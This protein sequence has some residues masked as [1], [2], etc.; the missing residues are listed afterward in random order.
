MKKLIELIVNDELE[1][2]SNLSKNAKIRKLIELLNQSTEEESKEFLKE[3]EEVLKSVPMDRVNVVREAF[4]YICSEVKLNQKHSTSNNNNDFNSD[5]ALLNSV[6]HSFT[7]LNKTKLN[8]FYSSLLEI[9]RPIEHE[10][11]Y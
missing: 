1:N 4:E 9:D 11:D 3:F 6:T 7:C 2:C 10:F 8:Y 5:N